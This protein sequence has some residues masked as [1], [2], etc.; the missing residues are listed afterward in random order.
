MR[1][2]D[3]FAPP[4]EVT[5]MY[6]LK[7]SVSNAYPSLESANY[8][9][10]VGTRTTVR[11]VRSICLLCTGLL[12]LCGP[13]SADAQTQDEN[14]ARIEAL[15][16]T[17]DTLQSQMA[18]VQTELKR[19]SASTGTAPRNVVE[20]KPVAG[21]Q[22]GETKSEVEEELKPKQQEIGKA[23]GSYRTFTQDPLAAPRLN[24]EPLDPR[25]PGYF[26]LPGTSTLLR[27][28]G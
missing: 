2:Q 19:L 6:S 23:T 15:Q 24:N 16:K 9:F 17:L 25:F 14:R 10:G 13:R 20:S 1:W 8:K 18:D 28:G 21:A 27:I 3:N 26:R 4:R 7:A 12:M 5:G 11:K 22:Q